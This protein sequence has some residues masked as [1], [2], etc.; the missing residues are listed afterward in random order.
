[1]YYK[2]FW[3]YVIALY[4]IAQLEKNP[5]AMQETPVWFLV[6]EEPLEKG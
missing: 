1:M 2:L 5:P 3:K 6:R 4:V